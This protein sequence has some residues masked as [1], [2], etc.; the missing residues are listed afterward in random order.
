[1]VNTV[2]LPLRQ[3]SA[4]PSPV[5]LGQDPGAPALSLLL[6]RRSGGSGV[7]V[8]VAGV[9]RGLWVVRQAQR[10][11]RPLLGHPAQLEMGQEGGQAKGTERI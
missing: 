8:Q 3:G 11:Q 2:D 10:G 1:M 6:I 4:K 5:E 9:L 7:G